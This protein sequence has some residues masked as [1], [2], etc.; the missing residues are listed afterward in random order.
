MPSGT[1]DPKTLNVVT[2]IP[3]GAPKVTFVLLTTSP[4]TF[5]WIK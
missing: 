5:A 4:S 3:I 1:P 2:S